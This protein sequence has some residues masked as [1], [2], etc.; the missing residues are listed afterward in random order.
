M[1]GRKKRK[2]PR[3][4]IVAL[5]K[6]VAGTKDEEVCDDKEG[7]EAYGAL[8]KDRQVEDFGEGRKCA[9][10]ECSLARS[11]PD[12]LCM[13]CDSAIAEWKNFLWNRWEIEQRIAKHC[14]DY[15]RAKLTRKKARHD[16]PREIVSGSFT[17]AV[18]RREI[19]R[20][21]KKGRR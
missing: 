21:V 6:A 14:L 15:V 19:G 18:G 7:K 17:R 3:V 9:C 10:C 11:N 20:K 1:M 8:R 4:D 13:P 12:K 5:R 16:V 2:K